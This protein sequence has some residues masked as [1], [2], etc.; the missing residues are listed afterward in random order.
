MTR[1]DW[2][3]L[4]VVLILACAVPA[5]AEPAPVRMCTANVQNTPDL[6]SEEV[7]EDVRTARRACDLILWQ[8]IGEREDYRAVTDT[9]GGRWRTTARARGGVPISWRTDRLRGAGEPETIR[10][11]DPTPR[12]RDGSPSYNPARWVTLAPLQVRATGQRL[13]AI[14]L[15]FPQRG[16]CRKADRADRWRQAYSTTQDHLPAGPLVVGGDWNRREPEIPAMTRWHWTTPAPRSLD[17]IA[18]A[19]TGWTVA[20]KFTRRLN[21]D[22]SL[23][24]AVLNIR[25]ED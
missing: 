19:R 8:E 21:S 11:S 22:H 14:S 10:V 24:G 7:R 3:A 15:H 12:C 25:Q 9:L 20:D 17:H 2:A 1:R 5:R 23:Q 4:V 6:L 16:G 18:I 13:T